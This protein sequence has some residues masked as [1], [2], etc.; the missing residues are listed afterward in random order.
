MSSSG[1]GIILVSLFLMAA[2]KEIGW[3]L[4]L[5]ALT[6]THMVAEFAAAARRG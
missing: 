6:G 3:R 5:Q 4:A 2:L 1:I